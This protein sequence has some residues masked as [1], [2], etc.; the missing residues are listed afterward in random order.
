MGRIIIDYPESLPPALAVL[1][2]YQV[3]QQGKMSEASG[4]PH[5]CWHTVF[6]DSTAVTT[7]R[8]KREQVSDSF[9]VTDEGRSDD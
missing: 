2:V 1:R 8:K 4:V 3:I 5:Y 7:R 9:L 6:V